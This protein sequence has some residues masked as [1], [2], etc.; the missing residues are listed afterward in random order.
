MRSASQ[1]H[2][3]EI[4]VD[5]KRAIIDELLTQ[6]HIY[7][8]EQANMVVRTIHEDEDVP[9]SCFECGESLREIYTRPDELSR[10]LNDY[11]LVVLK[12]EKCSLFYAVW[13]QPFTYDP[14]FLEPAIEDEKSG[15]RTIEPAQ[16]NQVGKPQ[17]GEGIQPKFSKK[18]AMAY[19]RANSQLED[20][21]KRLNS[22][23]QDK[24]VE[25]HSHDLS[26]ETI[27]IA[28]TKVVNYVKNTPLTEKKLANLLAAAIYQASHEELRC[29]GGAV[30]R[31]EKLS[32][33]KIEEIFG[34]TRKTIRKWRK[35]LPNRLND[36]YL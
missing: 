35:Q 12:C 19:A 8:D 26:S 20:I 29:I 15:G 11:D 17:W 23:I 18:T 27:N 36:L 33:R 9:T 25:M 14:T 16:W 6:A 7:L 34:V 30:R 4:K 31:G 22:I 1:I 13:I 10:N 32:E 28:R 24:L 5:E 21:D 2:F 3:G